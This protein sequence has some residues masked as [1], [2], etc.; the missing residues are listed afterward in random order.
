MKT[1]KAIAAVKNALGD[2]RSVLGGAKHDLQDLRDRISDLQAKRQ[3]AELTSVDRAEIERRIKVDIARATE[4]D[5][6]QNW[7]R[8][9]YQ[10]PKQLPLETDIRRLIQADPLAVLIGM[11]GKDG[12]REALLRAAA[13]ATG[14][15]SS[16]G[17]AAEIARLDEEIAVAEQA[18]ELLLREI[19]SATGAVM[20]RRADASEKILLAPDN[21]LA[22]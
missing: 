12:V 19:E 8:Q 11:L 22:G 7:A 2:L 21:E 16:R 3:H 10:P 5:P 15:L 18:E 14:G 17:R 20:P 1:P 13:P 4:R 6:F 9:W